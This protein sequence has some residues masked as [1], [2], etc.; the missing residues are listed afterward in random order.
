MPTFQSFSMCIWLYENR[1]GIVIRPSVL[2]TRNHEDPINKDKGGEACTSKALWG[3]ISPRLLLDCL[4]LH[5]RLLAVSIRN[6]C[7]HSPLYLAAAI[8]G[9]RA[10]W[11]GKKHR[12]NSG[13]FGRFG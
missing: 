3:R 12:S 5:L 13:T 10:S 11:S 1:L 7:W 2:P 4:C 6:V 8:P 9:T